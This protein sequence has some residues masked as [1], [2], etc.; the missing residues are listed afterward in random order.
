MAIK[1]PSQKAKA[2][3]KVVDERAL[4]EFVSRVDGK[5]IE[6]T[7]NKKIPMTFRASKDEHDSL[8]E[9]KERKGIPIQSILHLALAEY[10]ERNIDTK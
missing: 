4:D 5:E 6:P 2:A 3:E 8:T 10:L 9:L 7:K 1:T